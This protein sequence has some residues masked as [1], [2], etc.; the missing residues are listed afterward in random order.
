MHRLFSG[1]RLC[2]TLLI[3][4]VGFGFCLSVQAQPNTLFENVTLDPANFSPDPTT[5]RGISGGELGA[6]EAAGRPETAT[7]A[8]TGFVD[9]QPDHTI[10]LSG[11]FNYLSLQVESPEDTTLIVRGPGGTWCNDDYTGKNPGIAG[12]W[13]SG[14]YEIWVGSYRQNEFS[15]YVI[16]MTTQ[17]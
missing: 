15:P 16:R 13:L 9:Q 1:L 14:T 3:P 5:V 11:V 2:P 4:I 7:G 17:R 12:Q 10:V 8:C 6:S